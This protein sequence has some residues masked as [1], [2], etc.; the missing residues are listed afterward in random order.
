MAASRRWLAFALTMVGAGCVGQVSPPEGAPGPAADVPAVARLT[1]FAS[2]FVGGRVE[3]DELVV[4]DLRMGQHPDYVFQHVV[5]TRGNPH[6]HPIE[7]RRVP[8]T[9]RADRLAGLWDLIW[10]AP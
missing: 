6:W 1:W 9:M 5:A 8:N 7:S 4:T 2:G 10:R 3:G